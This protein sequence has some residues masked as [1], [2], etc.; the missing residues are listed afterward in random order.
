[1]VTTWV[2]PRVL[3]GSR[4]GAERV[5]SVTARDLVAVRHSAYWLVVI[6]GFIEPVLYLFSI[7]IGVG[8][9]VPNFTLPD[10]RV[11]AYATFVAPGML[12]ASAMNGALAE[13]TYN[14]FAKLHW[15]R[16]YES[17]IATP[18]RPFEIALGELGWALIRGVLYSAAFLGLMI[19]LGLTTVGWAVPA[20]LASL[21]VGFA[22]GAAGMALAT[23]LRTWQD[24]D[25]LAVIQFGMFMFSGTF[26]P[27]SSF[28]PVLQVVI[29]I[30]PLYQAV[31][32]LRALTL[33]HPTW[34]TL[35]NLAYLVALAAIGIY[36]AGRRMSR[37]L[38]P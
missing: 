38:C 10:G 33:G 22:F 30:T 23:L 18:L 28:G 20:L 17:M 8:G 6:S 2:L 19:G 36:F 13:S 35:G 32:L 16:L 34:A 15:A 25:Y 9:L 3:A 24:F 7:G 26:V 27:A 5:A 29:Q 21:A 31:E 4:R 37:K 1:M 14:F 11:I 12:A